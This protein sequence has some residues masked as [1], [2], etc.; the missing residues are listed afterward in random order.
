MTTAVR[1]AV[2]GALFLIPFIPLYVSNS[3]FFPFITGKHFAFRILVEIAV[4]GWGVLMLIDPKYRPRFSWTLVL[5][6][7]LVAWM[8]I[9]NLLAVNPEKAFWSNYERMDGW[10]TLVHVFGFFLVAGSV[11]A[12]EKLWRKWWL[13][14]LGASAFVGLYGL[15]QVMGVFTIHQGGV[16]L[17]ATLGNAAYL[18]AYLLFVIAAAIW[19]A[20]TSKGWLRYSLFAL[21]ALQVFLL[22]LTATRGALL[23]AVM[24]VLAGALLWMFT[25]TGKARRYGVGL[26]I[27]L[28]VAIGGFFLVRD[29]AFVRE[30]PTLARF[31]SLSLADGATRFTLWDMAVKGVAERPLTGW[32]QEGFNYIFNE[33]YVPSLYAQEPWFDRAHNVYID[34]LTAGGIPAMLLFI[35]LLGMGAYTIYRKGERYERVMLVAAVTAYAFQALFVFDNLFS[36]VPLAAILAVAHAYG[37]R[38]ITRLEELPRISQGAFQ[39]VAA[40]VGFVVAAVLVWSVNAPSMLAANDLIRAL[41]P[42]A[43]PR[44]N[45]EAFSVALSRNGLGQQEVREQMV[46]FSAGIVQ[47]AA[48][49]EDIRT[50]VAQAAVTEMEK[51]VNEVPDDARLRVQLASAYRTLGDYESAMREIRVAQ[52]LSPLKQRLILEEGIIALQAKDYPAA[53]AAF[54]RAYELD[55]SFDELAVYAASGEILIGNEAGAKALLAERFGT[56]TID[57]NV[58]LLA[59]YERKDYAEIV[60]VLRSRIEA[61]PNEP[62]HYLQLASMYIEWGRSQDARATFQ[63]L[64]TARP[65][66]VM[67][68]RQYQTQLGL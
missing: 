8:F 52:E 28:L 46:A 38:P 64:M 7:A 36:Y 19:Q 20:L 9:A 67:Q 57:N 61:Q 17:D 18:A 24:G 44:A 54:A 13:T 35:A 27:A 42:S 6:G 2:L 48:V 43:D 59:Y 25:S 45:L 30:D 39:N 33:H 49:P 51:Q 22:F 65:D 10:V 68:V 29:T 31:A 26:L 56:S 3:L 58:I 23:G 34:W 11:L 32:G 40:P 66:L 4:V 53:H 15:L 1:Y 47:Q 60:P 41:T 63:S 37:S 12:A 62:S 14:F 5:Y 16:R 21:A 55:T 50:A